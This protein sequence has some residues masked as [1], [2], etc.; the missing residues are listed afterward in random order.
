M[1]T[2]TSTPEQRSQELARRHLREN[3]ELLT[4]AE[5]KVIESLL[6]GAGVARNTNRGFDQT[7]T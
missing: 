6:S 1:S 3:R 5:R 7:L 4:V 2:V